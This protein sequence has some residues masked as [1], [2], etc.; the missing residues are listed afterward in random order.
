MLKVLKKDFKSIILNMFKEVTKTVSTEQSVRVPHQIENTKKDTEIFF[1]NQKDILEL[2]SL[3]N[4]NK[5]HH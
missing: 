5:K 2:K 1:M 3:I 4:Y